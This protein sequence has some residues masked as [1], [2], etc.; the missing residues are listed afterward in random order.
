VIWPAADVLPGVTKALL[1]AVHRGPVR[2]EPV[3]PDQLAR[4]TAAFATNAGW[5]VRAVAAIDGF[6][7]PAENAMLRRL[8]AEY[9][10]IRPEKI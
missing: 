6:E 2:T 8:R 10:A 9:A 1:A 3:S 4:M 7:W 5:G